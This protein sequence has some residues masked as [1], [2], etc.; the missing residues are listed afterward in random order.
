VS[1][2][3]DPNSDWLTIEIRNQAVI[4]EQHLPHIFEQF[5]RIPGTNRSQQ[6]TGLG[7][8][9]VQKLVKQLNGKIKVVSRGGW[10]EFAVELPTRG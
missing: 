2:A 10:T 3:G 7:L 4:S 8:S 1:I 9:L 5:Y 6:G